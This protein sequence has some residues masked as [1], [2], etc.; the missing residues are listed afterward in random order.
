MGN[1]LP[2]SRVLWTV[3]T[4]LEMYENVILYS[5]VKHHLV[6]IVLSMVRM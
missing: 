1:S 3:N 6:A 5:F 4:R 2:G